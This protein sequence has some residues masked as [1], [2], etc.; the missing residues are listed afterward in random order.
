M[1]Q[2]ET[3]N[4]P[5]QISVVLRLENSAVN[6][7]DYCF[8]ITRRQSCTVVEGM[9]SGNRLLVTLNKLISLSLIVL[10]CKWA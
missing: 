7:Y 9:G 3:N 2:L 1:E 8:V 10:I 4:Y 5:S 6:H